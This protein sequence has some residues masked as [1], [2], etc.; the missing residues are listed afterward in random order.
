MARKTDETGETAE[1]GDAIAGKATWESPLESRE[2]QEAAQDRKVEGQ[3]S[4]PQ[5][6]DISMQR[7]DLAS[8]INP[9]E[10]ADPERK[11]AAAD[12]IQFGKSIREARNNVLGPSGI[13][14]ATRPLPTLAEHAERE[15]VFQRPFGSEPANIDT[16]TGRP[17]VPGAAPAP[18]NVDGT[19]VA[20]DV[21]AGFSAAA[22]HGT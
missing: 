19:D 21:D 12:A 20:A 13:A 10:I 7:P 17:I 18:G 1:T 11:Q 9:D 16:D 3:E 14:A 4:A 5:V 22:R 8:R 15:V 6:Q 2:A